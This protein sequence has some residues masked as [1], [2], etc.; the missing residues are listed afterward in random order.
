MSVALVHRAE[1]RPEPP[2]GHHGSPRSS[3][4]AGGWHCGQMCVH[5]CASSSLPNGLA[6]PAVGGWLLVASS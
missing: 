5:A 2:S 6:A 3:T 4:V 1:V